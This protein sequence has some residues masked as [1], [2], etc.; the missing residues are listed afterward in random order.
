VRK[1]Q[2]RFKGFDEKIVAM[3]ARGMTTRDIEGHLSEIYGASV[4]RDTI[5][6]VTAAVLGD[7]KAW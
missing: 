3:Y 2:R 1:G 7:A 4:G 5:S 6:R